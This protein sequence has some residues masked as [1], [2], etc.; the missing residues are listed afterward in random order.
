[1]MRG[2]RLVPTQFRFIAESAIR[3]RRTYYIVALVAFAALAFL[4]ATWSGEGGSRGTSVLYGFG[5]MMAAAPLCRSW[6]ND[7]VR[8]GLGAWW[9]QKPITAFDL[10]QARLI[11]LVGWAC[12]ASAVVT[13]TLGLA[14]SLGGASL[15]LIVDLFI[16]AGWLPVLL[17]VLAFLGSAL[18]VRNAALF[19]Y[20]LF[21]ISGGLR[22]LSDSFQVGFLLDILRRILPPYDSLTAMLMTMAVHGRSAAIPMLRPMLAYIVVCAALGLVVSLTVP[23]R[24]A[25]QE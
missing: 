24:L 19:A 12:L 15:S 23:R 13:V 5:L 8:L 1:M 11:A 17:V 10:Y 14:A 25:G 9:L 7:D 21:L 16:A 18:G 6:V 22:G 3:V 20:G 2:I 4:N